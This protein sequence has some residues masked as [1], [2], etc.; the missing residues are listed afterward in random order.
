MA[1]I[2]IK[3]GR[4]CRVQLSITTP[5][6]DQYQSNLSAAKQVGAEIDF[7]DEFEAWFKKQNDQITRDLKD[8]QS[9]SRAKTSRETC[10]PTSEELQQSLEKSFPTAGVAAKNKSGG[11]DHGNNQTSPD[12]D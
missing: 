7:G 10:L 4:R 12:S 11:D 9:G 8:L 3:Q 5:L 1:R 6:W 2:K